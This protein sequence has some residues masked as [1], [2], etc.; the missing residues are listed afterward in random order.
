MNATNPIETLAGAM[1]HAAYE[2]FPEYKYKDRDWTK[3]DKW[4]REVFDKLS[5]EEKKK[6]YDEERRTNVHMCPA[7]CLVEK[8][9][10]HTFY[11]LTVY[12][13]FPQ[14]WGSTALG[15]G[16]IGGQAITSAYVCIIESNL[17]GQFAVYFGGQLAYV[18]ERPN[19]K[20]ME[21]I[22]RQQMTDAKLGKTTYERTN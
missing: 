4:R 2:A 9:R 15:F 11:D 22:A 10:K 6:L 13:M 21:D 7:D 19:E 18:I 16:G 5:N 1:A 12:N 20:F 3:Y 17:L 14:T 8:S